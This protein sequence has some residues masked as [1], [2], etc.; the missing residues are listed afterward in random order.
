[1]SKI[2]INGNRSGYSPDQ[3]GRTLTAQQLIDILSGF[4][5][6]SPVYLKNDGGYTYGA[7]TD[8]DIDEEEDTEEEEESEDC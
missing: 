6:D 8:W 5:P 2:F 4:D 3:C 7:I 1:M